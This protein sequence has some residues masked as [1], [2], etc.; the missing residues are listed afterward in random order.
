[1]EIIEFNNLTYKE[2]IN[3]TLVKTHLKNVDL[4]ILENKITAILGDSKSGIEYIGGLVNASIKPSNGC[5]KVLSFINDGKRIKN[6]NNLRRLIGIVPMYPDK[7]LFSKTVKE[8]LQFGPS[9]FK[10][11]NDKTSIRIKEALK[12][13][14]LDEKILN[15]KISNLTLNEQRKVSLASV[16]IFNPKILILDNITFLLTNKDKE[17]IKK[18]IIMLKEKYNKTIILLTKDTDF[19]YLL[20]DRVVIFNKGKKVIE[21][22]TNLLEDESLLSM[23]N[24]EVPNIVKFINTSRKHNIPLT[25]T[26]DILDLIKEVYRNAR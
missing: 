16:L 2:Y 9:H 10:Y 3:H 8:E 20:A 23:N 4:T 21:G 19:A 1:M 7:I 14:D 12:I 24:L 11:K 17:N 15:E 13:L 5:V 25:Y 22:S 6:V 26:K 18:L